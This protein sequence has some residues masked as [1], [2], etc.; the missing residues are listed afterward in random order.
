M[1]NQKCLFNCF[2]PY[3]EVELIIEKKGVIQLGVGLIIQVCVESIDVNHLS[4]VKL[5]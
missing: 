1:A 5:M 2:L 4:S 3:M